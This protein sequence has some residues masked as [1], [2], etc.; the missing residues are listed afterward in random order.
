MVYSW[1]RKLV[2]FETMPLSFIKELKS[3]AEVSINDIMFAALGGAI[4]R[5]NV[6]QECEITEKK[7]KKDTSIQCRALM[8]VA[9][10]RPEEDNDDKTKVMRNKWVFKE[11]TVTYSQ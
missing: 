8:P 11:G 9:F 10:P 7:G 3:K 6:A 2:K 5:M 1:D 4:R